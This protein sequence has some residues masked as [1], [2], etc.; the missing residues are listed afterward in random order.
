MKT[1]RPCAGALALLLVAG[2]HAT[3]ETIRAQYKTN[4]ASGFVLTYGP[5]ASV[6]LSVSETESK[7]PDGSA[8]ARLDFNATSGTWPEDFAQIGGGG[9]IPATAVS[10]NSDRIQVDIDDVGSVPGFY[11]S[12]YR[13]SQQI[14]ES[15]TPTAPVAVHLTI[16]KSRVYT[17]HMTGT[18]R[19]HAEMVLPAGTTYDE[20]QNGTISYSEATAEGVVADT[21]LPIADAVVASA[22]TSLSRGVIVWVTRTTP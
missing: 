20:T 13:C 11:L 8:Q 21:A 2:P 14:C 16:K 3:A 1:T 9:F 5:G 4:G 17:V 6:Y 18:R 15:F 10:S 7:G 12:G 19:L 22:S